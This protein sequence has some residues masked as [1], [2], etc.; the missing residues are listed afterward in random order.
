MSVFQLRLNQNWT[1]SQY[2]NITNTIGWREWRVL[3]P[4][5]AHK[6]IE[7]MQVYVFILKCKQVVWKRSIAWMY[8]MN[9]CA[10][11][12]YKPNT[13][14]FICV[15]SD[16]AHLTYTDMLSCNVHE[17]V[18]ESAGT[19]NMNK[20]RKKSISSFLLFHQSFSHFFGRF[21]FYSERTMR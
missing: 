7:C 12:H 18:R 14:Y 10:S 21:L 2:Y 17:C 20:R 19:M 16:D 1:H 3:K 6:F 9:Q 11:F 8:L 4:E 5:N 15:S 13:W